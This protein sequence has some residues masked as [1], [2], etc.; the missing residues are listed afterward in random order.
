MTAETKEVL[1]KIQNPLLQILRTMIMMQ[2]RLRIIMLM[3]TMRRT[4]GKLL[5]RSISCLKNSGG[6]TFQLSGQFSNFPT[7]S[8]MHSK[9]RKVQ[10]N[11]LNQLLRRKRFCMMLLKI[12]K[13][14]VGRSFSGNILKMIPQKPLEI[15]LTIY[16]CSINFSIMPSTENILLWRSRSQGRICFL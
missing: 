15:T 13:M 1:K 9:F 8:F 2:R 6:A 7:S 3:A 16:K 12:T 11:T 5:I 10:K 4:S 14:Q